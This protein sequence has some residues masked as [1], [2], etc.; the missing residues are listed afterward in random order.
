MDHD[1]TKQDSLN[2]PGS[3]DEIEKL[4]TT[5]NQVSIKQCDQSGCRQKWTKRNEAFS[6]FLLDCDLKQPHERP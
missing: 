4:T 5:L 2:K 1:K 3:P 6:G